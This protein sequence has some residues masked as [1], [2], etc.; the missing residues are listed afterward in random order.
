MA[1][2]KIEIG[3]NWIWIETIPITPK[4]NSEL[5]NRIPQDKMWRANYLSHII[6]Q[7]KMSLWEWGDVSFNVISIIYDCIKDLLG[8]YKAE[9]QLLDDTIEKSDSNKFVGIELKNLVQQRDFLLE[10][11]KNKEEDKKENIYSKNLIKKIQGSDKNTS[12]EIM[13]F[14]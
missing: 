11:I 4:T 12:Q 8:E 2:L 6:K 7:P 1:K 10:S 3:N 5:L 9:L 13:Y 14:F